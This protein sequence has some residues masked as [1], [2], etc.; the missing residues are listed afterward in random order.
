MEVYKLLFDYAK[1]QKWDKFVNELK[2]LDDEHT[3]INIKDKDN[4][5]LISYAIIYNKPEIVKLLI[6]KSLY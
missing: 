5:Y 2:N 6:E 1:N 3:D 4:N